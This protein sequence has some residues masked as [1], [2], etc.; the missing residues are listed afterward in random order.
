MTISV[1]GIL[2]AALV[3]LAGYGRI[4]RR[5]RSTA[6]IITGWVLAGLQVVI[7]LMLGMPLLRQWND[8]PGFWPNA[9]LLD[10]AASN[11]A[12]RAVYRELFRRMDT[13][14]MT[15]SQNEQFARIVV[16]QVTDPNGHASADQIWAVHQLHRRGRLSHKQ[17]EA[18]FRSLDARQPGGDGSTAPNRD[19]R[20]P[21]SAPAG[22]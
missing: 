19:R 1:L 18:F 5:R 14:T 16:D 13:G 6:L 2:V 11:R 17:T 12:S 15:P 8:T 22:D 7:L 9:L 4:G 10:R 20:V 3:L 21:A